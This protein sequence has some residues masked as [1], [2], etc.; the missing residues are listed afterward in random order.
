MRRPVYKLARMG[1]VRSRSTADEQPAGAVAP[2]RPPAPAP[3][4]KWRTA[5]ATSAGEQRVPL[6]ADL[7]R[8]V[9]RA[10]AT[11]STSRPSSLKSFAHPPAARGTV[12]P[13]A[14]RPDKAE[15]AVDDALRQRLRLV[16]VHAISFC[17]G[18]PQADELCTP[19]SHPAASEATFRATSARV[20]GAAADPLE[21]T[22]AVTAGDATARDQQP[23]HTRW[24]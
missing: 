2:V 24:C 10:A 11:S 13:A 23:L 12:S 19:L 21:R 18:A 15:Q 7:R 3:R 16:S 20:A 4:R 14:P 8:T 17:P 9:R 6:S 22:G 1:I 5:A